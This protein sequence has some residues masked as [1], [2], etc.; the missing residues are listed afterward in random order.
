MMMTT[1]PHRDRNK[2]LSENITD[3]VLTHVAGS[4]GALIGRIIDHWVIVWLGLHFG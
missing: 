3:D 4:Q 2:I 1:L